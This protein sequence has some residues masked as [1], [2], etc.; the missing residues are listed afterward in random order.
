MTYHDV[1]VRGSHGMAVHEVYKLEGRAI[2]GQR[3]SR[4]VVAV[5]PKFAV[6]VGAEL[7][8]EVVGRL[9]VG[10]LKVVFA[11][12]AGLPYVKDG[13]GDRSAGEEVGDGAVHSADAAAGIDVL[14]DGATV[15]AERSVWRPKGAENGR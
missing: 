9:V 7:A 4:R 2:R 13:A 5:E 14:D 12:G 3:I 6:L 8:A 11:I 1:N 15:L 10:V